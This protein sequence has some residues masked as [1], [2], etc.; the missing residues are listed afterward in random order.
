MNLKCPIVNKLLLVFLSCLIIHVN[1]YGQ[2]FS[3]D[4]AETKKSIRSSKQN[5]RPYYLGISMGL[6]NPSGLLGFQF[7]YSLK[8]TTGV[9]AHL[10]LGTWGFKTA[11]LYHYFRQSCHRGWNYGAGLSLASGIRNNS[12][13]LETISG[14]KNVQINCLP[15]LGLQFNIM[16]AI[17]LGKNGHRLN[18]G[19]GWNQ[20]ITRKVYTVNDANQL[21]LQADRLLNTLCP[22]GLTLSAAYSIGFGGQ[23]SC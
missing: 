21:T 19:G 23:R 15:Q 12:L 17:A 14:Y 22:G 18:L 1:G 9:S 7:D 20:R 4:A 8:P 16:R 13:N 2:S 10:G 3:R 6:N 5:C 11:F